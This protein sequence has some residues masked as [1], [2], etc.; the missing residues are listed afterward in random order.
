LST[1]GEAVTPT[2]VPEAIGAASQT[3]S[4]GLNF[5]GKWVMDNLLRGNKSYFLNGAEP[6][7]A[8]QAAGPD[9]SFGFSKGNLNKQI[10]NAAA[11]GKDTV[12]RIVQNSKALIPRSA[13]QGVVDGI[14]SKSDFLKRAGGDLGAAGKLDDLRD[15][16]LPHFGGPSAAMPVQELHGLVQDLDQHI[17]RD[18]FTDPST[19]DVVGARQMIRNGLADLLTKAEPRLDGPLQQSQGLT[20]AEQLMN[21]RLSDPNSN[22]VANAATAIGGGMAAGH[23]LSN[24]Y[25][26]IAGGAVGAVLPEIVKSTV[27]HSGVATGLSQA[28]DLLPGAGDFLGSIGRYAGPILP[29]LGTK[30]PV[31]AWSKV[32][33]DEEEGNTNTQNKQSGF[34]ANQGVSQYGMPHGSPSLFRGS[35]PQNPIPHSISSGATGFGNTNLSSTYPTN[36]L[37]SP[38]RQS[39]D[40][41]YGQASG[42]VSNY[43]NTPQ[44]SVEDNDQKFQGPPIILKSLAPAAFPNGEPSRTNLYGWPEYQ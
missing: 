22:P 30:S 31:Q 11:N 43:F 37:F 35:W 14:T 32:I 10:A 8:V 38:Y 27:L 33:P 41:G 40:M 21:D 4:N 16:Y 17:L 9:T 1:V 2:A 42:K 39:S 25:G 24:P 36:N 26:T 7:L 12:A 15:S 6:G 28:G 44:A 13:V 18:R 34:Q 3:V 29:Q 20:T 19:N 5:S 23:L